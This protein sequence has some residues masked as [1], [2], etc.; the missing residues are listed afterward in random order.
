MLSR[1][2]FAEAEASADVRA[3]GLASAQSELEGRQRGLDE[4]SRSVA[5]AQ[6]ELRERETRFQ[7][8]QERAAGD[9]VS[10]QTALAETI[11]RVS[12][13]LEQ[14]SIQSG[15]RKRRREDLPA[16]LPADKRRRETPWQALVADV[17]AE[18]DAIDPE[19]VGQEPG[20]L[21][22]YYELSVA[23]LNA[24]YRRSWDDFVR[25]GAPGAWYCVNTLLGSGHEAAE[26]DGGTCRQHDGSCL[27]VKLVRSGAETRTLFTKEDM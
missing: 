19:E 5:S 9:V 15:S 6:S 23:F 24:T 7:Q 20:L 16:D 3:R 4:L 1:L 14:V 8:A 2:R 13:Q 25:A 21:T 10:S 11:Q 27:L 18:L 26:A 17:A 22:L 12:G